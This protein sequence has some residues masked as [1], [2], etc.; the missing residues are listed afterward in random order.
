MCRICRVKPPAAS[1]VMLTWNDT[2][3]WRIRRRGTWCWMWRAWS[4]AVA[5]RWF[6]GIRSLA[7]TITLICWWI[8]YGTRTQ[9]RQP[10]A[11]RWMTSASISMVSDIPK[12]KHFSYPGAS[13]K[14]GEWVIEYEISSALASSAVEAAKE[15]K[16]A[17][18]YRTGWGWC[19]N[20]GY[21]Y[22]AEKVCDTTLDDD[23]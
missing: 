3:T 1:R 23:K 11:L 22:S 19:P 5:V 9:Q 10:F 17:R 2:S 16:L 15:A 21:T 13:N 18:R 6:S 14:L 8:S 4:A 20:L 12:H 7:R